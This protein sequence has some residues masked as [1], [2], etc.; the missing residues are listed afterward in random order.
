M[1][2]TASRA[3]DIVLLFALAAVM[4]GA[5]LG[6]RDP[7]PA[8]EPRFALVA[9]QMVE[10]G[11]YLIPHR[12]IEP[13][14]DKPPT[15]MWLQA[16]AFHATGNW[17]IAFLL[18]SL[19]A[20]LG[21]LALV[22]DLSRRLASHRAGVLAAA[23]LATTAHFAFQSKHAQIDPLVTFWITLSGYG[24]LRHLLRGPDWRWWFVGWA[25]A[26]AGIITKGVGFL[27]LLLL[28]PYA[29]ARWRRWPLP[30]I[31]LRDWRWYAGPLAL[32]AVVALW[33][34]PLVLS[35]YGGDDPELRAYADDLLFRQTAG[36]YANP[37]HHV[38]PWWYYVPIV[39]LMW[40][41]WSALL[42]WT[43]PA[44]A[45]RWRRRDAH[46]LLPL[47]WAALVVV[48]FSLSPGKRDVYI[49]P[50]LPL[51]CVATAPLLPGLLRLRGVQRTLFALAVAAGV[52]FVA[53]SLWAW[54]GDAPFEQRLQSL[55]DV[56]PW[57]Y[58]FAMGVLT[59]VA[60]AI[61]RPRRGALAWA[62]CMFF[63]WTLY[64][65]AAP[66]INDARS[67]RGVMQRAA[68]LIG[69]DAELALV[70]FKE[71]NLLLADRLV[72][73]WG[74]L[75]DWDTQRRHAVAWLREAPARRYVFILDRALGD[76][77]DRTKLREVGFAN[78]RHWFVFGADALVPGCVDTAVTGSYDPLD[79]AG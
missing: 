43:A 63:A 72:R 66:V 58:P 9:K 71:Q 16:A 31:P 73:E 33:I 54:F 26:G 55:R 3:R 8:D 1:P 59:L 18:P 11:E 4:L 74:F 35:A 36:R 40:L 6:L 67:A 70:G 25:A 48:F 17:R 23:L 46:V 29:Y 34:V 13:Y 57:P 41:P 76:C 30:A 14:S 42:P 5:G 7:W 20:A 69:P 65:L 62:A 22:Y 51:L 68:A 19:L 78:R 50:A 61:A 12:G 38:Q 77:I 52:L 27:A 79:E 45:R 15:F 28:V 2:D 24:L 56:N 21:T 32:V 39:L 49:L 47:A 53:A 44:W 64:G 37:W 60:C 10:S 75:T